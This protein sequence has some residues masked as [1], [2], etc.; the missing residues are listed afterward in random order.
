MKTLFLAAA[1][2]LTLGMG[3]A[4]AATNAP[5]FDNAQPAA[6]SVQTGNQTDPTGGTSV[7]A[8][9]GAPST[10]AYYSPNGLVPRSAAPALPVARPTPPGAEEA[11][12][13]DAAGG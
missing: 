11:Y 4:F 2:A 5:G 10:Y 13:S 6:T 1:A 7:V 8:S 12:Q 3:A 9:S